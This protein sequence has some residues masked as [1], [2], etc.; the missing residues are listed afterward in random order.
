ML[1]A[2]TA[3]VQSGSNIERVYAE[4]E[5]E[6]HAAW[7]PSSWFWFEPVDAFPTTILSPNAVAV[8]GVR[9][10]MNREPAGVCV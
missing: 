2:F 8:P 9:A 10:L 4:E 7:P 6:R 1:G 3:W 5:G